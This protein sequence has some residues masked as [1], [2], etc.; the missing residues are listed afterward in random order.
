MD[1][2][3]ALDHALCHAHLCA[4]LAALLRRSWCCRRRRP[5]V[6]PGVHGRKFEANQAGA[7][8]HARPRLEG[9]P[10][11]HT[12]SHHTCPLVPPTAPATLSPAAAAHL[13]SYSSCVS[14]WLCGHFD[15]SALRALL[16]NW[17]KCSTMKTH[18][19]LSLRLRGLLCRHRSAARER[20]DGLHG[21]NQLPGEAPT[22]SL[23]CKR[24][25]QVQA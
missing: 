8:L 16:K 2:A 22:G 15:T 5:L 14:S 1:H 3:P 11:H 18:I 9:C 12:R 6:L 19:I 17:S 25:S 21:A 10:I 7:P 24:P 23:H 20:R 13:F 4:C